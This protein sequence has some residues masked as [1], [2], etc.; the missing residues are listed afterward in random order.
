MRDLG[1]YRRMCK[2]RSP[3]ALQSLGSYVQF[4]IQCQ[5]LRSRLL[6]S[7][8]YCRG[9]TTEMPSWPVFL[10]TCSGDSS[11]WWAWQHGSSTACITQT[12]SATHS[13]PSIGSRLRT[14]TIQDGRA[15]VRGHSW[16]CTVITESTGSCRRSTWSAF[17]PL[18]LGQLSAGAV[19]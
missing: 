13:S 10:P 12:T 9:W 7:R 18:C 5:R 3:G 17:P 16:N 14:G 1:I 8:W 11:Q 6:S 4:V 15:H 19:R 2:R